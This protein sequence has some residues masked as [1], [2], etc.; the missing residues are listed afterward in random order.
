MTFAVKIH[1]ELIS[2]V[3]AYE[4]IKNEGKMGVSV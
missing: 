2:V 4:M 1:K 3:L